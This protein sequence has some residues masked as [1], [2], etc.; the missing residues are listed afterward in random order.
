M[1][2]IVDADGTA[3]FK[4]PLDNGAIPFIHLDDFGGYVHWA[5]SNLDES[6]GLDFGIAT[7][8]VSG[9]EIASA[10]TATTGKPAKYV[11]IST[12]EWNAKTW[13]GLPKG[14][15]TKVGFLSVKD[16][17]ALLQTYGQ[18][19]ANWWHL[20][21]SSAGN[22]GL[23]QRDYKLLDEI[24]PTRVKSVEEWMRKTGYTGERQTTLKILE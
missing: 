14:P 20:Y 13:K 1:A 24:L 10:L 17:N 23:I 9:P 5:L 2:P 19:F 15:D 3:V 7:A 18:N 22:K 21:Q 12:D 4:L 8:H 6:N 16:D 11:S